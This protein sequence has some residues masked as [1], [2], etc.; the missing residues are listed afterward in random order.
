MFEVFCEFIAG[1]SDDLILSGLRRRHFQWNSYVGL[2]R[3]KITGF[4][5]SHH[6]EKTNTTSLLTVHITQA[7]KILLNIS[8]LRW[9]SCCLFLNPSPN[10]NLA[11]HKMDQMLLFCGWQ[12]TLRTHAYTIQHLRFVKA[13]ADSTMTVFL[14]L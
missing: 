10:Q 11:C 7:M 14:L 6:W 12:M 9:L 2:S 13:W 3:W 5:D 8:H 1:F 4:N